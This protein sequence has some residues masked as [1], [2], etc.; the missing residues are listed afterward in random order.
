MT[1]KK[2]R[3]SP[4]RYAFQ[5]KYLVTLGLLILG[6][7]TCRRWEYGLLALIELLLIITL[8]D[9]L[10]R[11][12]T[13]VAVVLNA[14][15]CLLLNVQMILLFFGNS[16][17]QLVMLTN[18]ESLQDLAGKA[19]LYGTG[20]FL[21]IFFSLLPVAALPIKR[22]TFYIWILTGA[23]LL[24]AGETMAIRSL[25][26]ENSPLTNYGLLVNQAL[27]LREMKKNVEA[28]SQEASATDFYRDSVGDFRSKD[29]A[30]TEK[31]NVILIFTEGFS[32]NILTDERNITPNI[33]A[34]A[35]KSLNFEG[36]YNHTFATYR[37][38]IGQLYSGYQLENLDD[39]KLISLQDILK[40]QGYHTTFINTEPHNEDFTAYLQRLGFDDLLGEKEEAEGAALKYL[41]DKTAY[42]K[43]L[44][45]AQELEKAS[46]PFFLS[47]YTFGTHASL[48]SVDQKFGD[49][50]Q[51]FLNKFHD[52]D[53]QFGKFLE[54]FE[55]SSLSDNTLLILT[56][57]HCAYMDMD[58]AA[59]FRGYHRDSTT[60]DEVPL[61]FYYKG[62]TPE[63][64][65]V[66]GRNTLDL[67]PTLLD[68]LD[69]SA[70]NFFLGNSLFDGLHRENMVDTLFEEEGT[71]FDTSGRRIQTAEDVTEF[72][73]LLLKYYIAKLQDPSEGTAEQLESTN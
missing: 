55:D 20:A 49:G 46:Q 33:A 32:R 70:P 22:K 37:G 45:T 51:P 54:K 10:V 2:R 31:P 34:L 68:Y 8:S 58:F 13:P 63:T 19:L 59:A 53:Y 71:I 60:C 52:M 7:T 9:V 16:Y 30:L 14:I 48:D 56:A 5:I 24:A 40:K 72:R 42:E 66:A 67:A 35:E 3:I 44:D 11:I 15:A 57:D 6:M 41:S 29:T 36:Y 38:L 1:G 18:L 26:A 17:L 39:N 43:L 73:E 23:C 50:K 69:I 64:I 28:S 12:V 25:G 61:F 62:M 47:I 27:E 21:A 4:Y 65:D